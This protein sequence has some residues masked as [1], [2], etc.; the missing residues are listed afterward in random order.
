MTIQVDPITS[1]A[2]PG[3]NQVICVSTPTTVLSAAAFTTGIPVWSVNVGSGNLVSANSQ[4]TAITNLSLGY[5]KVTFSLITVGTCSSTSASMTIQV[6][7]APTQA[8]VG[9]TQTLCINNPTTNLTGNVPSLGAGTWSL[10]PPGAATIANTAAAN[11]QATLGLGTNTLVWRIAIAGVCPATSA[12][13]AVNVDQLASPSIAGPSYT[14]CTFS[15]PANVAATP[16]SV[17][18]GT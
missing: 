14:W 9:L 18:S 7:Q 15:G 11:S 16:I 10:V 13:L 17:G 1:I 8:S 12:S 3:P 6:D 5:N 4:T 2:N